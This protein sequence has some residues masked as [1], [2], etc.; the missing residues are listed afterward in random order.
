MSNRTR[1]YWPS[2]LFVLAMLFG[3]GNVSAQSSLL[4]EGLIGH[5]PLDG[6]AS[7]ISESENNG[8][9]NKGEADF[10]RFGSLGK[11][12]RFDGTNGHISIPDQDFLH[13]GNNDFTVS[14]WVKKLARNIGWSDVF[15]INA[16]RT[17]AL[18]GE[19]SWDLA[20]GSA[21]SND[22]P[23]FRFESGENTCTAS[24]G[25]SLYL[26]QWHLLTGVRE[27]ESLKLYIDGEL[28]ASQYVGDKS[29][30][31]H[32]G[33]II[34]GNNRDLSHPTH[35]VFD[36]LRLYNRAL[37]A[38]E[39]LELYNVGNYSQVKE[40][41]LYNGLVGHYPLDGNAYD[42]SVLGLDGMLDVGELWE[43]RFGR[44]GRAIRFNGK[45]GG[46][47]VPDHPAHRF[48]AKDFSVNIWVKKLAPNI[49]WSDVFGINRWDTGA[50][51]GTNEWGISLG[52]GS[53]SDV[54]R[55]AV[56]RDK[57]FLYAGAQEP[58]EMET[59][60]MLTGLRRGNYLEF[61]VNG[62]LKASTDIGPEPFNDNPGPLMVGTNRE[63]SHPTDA[64]FDDLRLY[65][66]ALRASEILDLYREEPV[67]RAVASGYWTDAST[68]ALGKVPEPG[69]GVTVEGHTVRLKTAGHCDRLEIKTGGKLVIEDRGIL[70]GKEEV[71]IG[72]G[73][74]AETEL[75]VEEGGRIRVTGEP[76]KKVLAYEKDFS[77]NVA[78]WTEMVYDEGL[79]C[80]R[81]PKD[82][83]LC[84]KSGFMALPTEAKCL[85]VR[86]TVYTHSETG[87][88]LNQKAWFFKG[89]HPNR[90]FIG[91][92]SKVRRD[93]EGGDVDVFDFSFPEGCEKF[94]CALSSGRSEDVLIR[95]VK[96]EFLVQGQEGGS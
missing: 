57:T 24:S 35:A 25:R 54:P 71:R 3:V 37:G 16:W 78:G 20:L 47:E 58:M 32:P 63:R 70:F 28:V 19:N 29:P 79:K 43:D 62:E 93:I 31:S 18:S 4:E 53:T 1:V 38:E 41:E 73:S 42:L 95:K 75:T 86:I 11:A 36:D 27:G 89:N 83:T 85:S 64:V 91:Q 23:Q 66:K 46:L 5:Y 59:W 90:E 96:I 7:D 65:G 10:D 72:Q 74:E 26:R 69:D 21:A 77:E 68:W 14:V 50:R 2:L 49:G 76:V 17:G 34:I 22:R 12:M 87:V 6:D 88:D 84:F 82:W 8:T 9:V 80:A 15:G 48:G 92:I 44:E 55:L 33:P 45:T 81:I 61:Y 67:C 52:S 39:A 60:Y 40:N 30:N 94:Q 51:R 13:F 56:E